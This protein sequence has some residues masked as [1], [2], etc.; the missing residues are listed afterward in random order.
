MN[1]R[2]TPKA[3]I[4]N[5]FFD[6]NK[7]NGSLDDETVHALA[8]ASVRDKY[9]QEIYTKI[10]F[11]EIN[12][13][14]EKQNL[15]DTLK[16]EKVEQTKRNVKSWLKEKKKLEK[17]SKLQLEKNKLE[18]EEKDR[19]LKIK[20][21]KNIRKWKKGLSKRQKENEKIEKRN[22]SKLASRPEWVGVGDDVIL[23]SKQFTQILDVII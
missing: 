23:L 13:V 19:Q 10:G 8:L 22:Q 7:N 14:S 6:Q 5:M 12:D 4:Y 3:H 1:K 21:K 18:Q 20:V 16:K 9:E 11:L 2:D 17:V 15:V